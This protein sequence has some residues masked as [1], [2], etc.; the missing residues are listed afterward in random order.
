MLLNKDFSLAA[1]IDEFKS[2]VWSDRYKSF[3]DFELVIPIDSIVYPIIKTDLYLQAKHSDRFMIIENISIDTDPEEGNYVT[4]TGRSL[5]SILDRRIV[6]NST[7]LTGNLQNGI[8][9]VINENI[10][11]PS[12]RNRKIPN[13]RFIVSEDPNVTKFEFDEDNADVDYQGK[14]VYELV[15]T[16]C[17]DN[18]LGFRITVDDDGWFNF[19]LYSGVDR[20][21]NQ[22]TNPWVVF[23]NKYENLLNTSY[24]ES[25]KDLKTA[26]LITG[27]D[28]ETGKKISVEV[29][30]SE[31]GG[32]GLERREMYVQ[33]KERMDDE[34]V[35]NLD[36]NAS[37]TQIS[38]AYERARKKY[39]TTMQGEGKDSLLNAKTVVAF[40]GEI[41]ATNQFVY[42]IDFFIGDIVQIVNEYGKEAGS[43]MEELVFT[44]DSSGETL[45][46]TFVSIEESSK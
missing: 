12:D 15:E 39:K 20:S 28:A 35:R 19:E 31:G 44:Q 30:D 38:A 23:S 26:V 43:R 4:V 24:Y 11:S 22:D 13:F 45:L 18:G 46:P 6:W 14:T 5:E 32:S 7:K 36:I 41:E 2:F 29:T 8:K 21:Y 10:I 40:D 27:D 16:F 25:N 42:G 37:D 17:K 9:K 33:S 1:M 3:G 34:E